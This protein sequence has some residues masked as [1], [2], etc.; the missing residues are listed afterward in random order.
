MEICQWF[1]L[2]ANE[3]DQCIIHPILGP[4]PCCRRCARKLD[5]EDQLLDM[6][7]TV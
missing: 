1:A 7:V 2:C 3:T 5:M 6:V 4:T